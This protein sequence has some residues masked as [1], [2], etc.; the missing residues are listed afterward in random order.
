MRV[1][2]LLPFLAHVCLNCSV[3]WAS[4]LSGLA[5][6]STTPMN[7]PLVHNWTP[8][9]HSSVQPWLTWWRVRIL[10]WDFWEMECKVRLSVM[11]ACGHARW[12]TGVFLCLFFF[13]PPFGLGNCNCM[14]VS[15]LPVVPCQFV[16]AQTSKLIF[17]N[18]CSSLLFLSETSRY[19]ETHQL[20][21][22]AIA[23]ENCATA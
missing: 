19:S 11:W 3:V 20:S 10:L 8:S 7:A 5:A 15:L 6:S 9:R 2:D 23:P 22:A 16:W 1:S 14:S 4:S 18:T 21:C 12:C 13:P 17:W